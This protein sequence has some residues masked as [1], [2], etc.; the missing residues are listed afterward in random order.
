MSGAV[1]S[2]LVVEDEAKELFGPILLIIL[3]VVLW[4]FRP[5]D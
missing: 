5:A 1:Y 2:R 3:T 4:H